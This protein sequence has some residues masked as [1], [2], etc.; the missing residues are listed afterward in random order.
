M[1]VRS[2]RRFDPV[3]ALS[4]ILVTTISSP[5]GASSST[6]CDAQSSLGRRR[7]FQPGFRWLSE[8]SRPSRVWL[9]I[10]ACRQSM[11]ARLNLARRSAVLGMTFVSSR[12][13]NG[14]H[15]S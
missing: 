14:V 9:A 2:S 1:L 11:P 7:S 12:S 15:R 13:W 8:R 6:I 3:R 10:R 4:V 5:T